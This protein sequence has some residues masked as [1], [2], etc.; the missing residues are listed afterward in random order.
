MKRFALVTLLL[1]SVAGA[2]V[3]LRMDNATVGPV[4]YLNCE[5]DAGLS[6]TRDAGAVGFLDCAVGTP[7]TRGCV[8]PADQSWTGP[9]RIAGGTQDVCVA[10]ASLTACSSP[11]AGLEQCCSTH[12]NAEVW[13]NGTTNV[14]LTGTTASVTLPPIYVNG[15]L[16]A[17]LAFLS[18][19]SLPYPYT[20][21]S[22][23]GYI[24]AGVGTTQTL[25]FSDGAN[26]CDCPIDCSAGATNLTCSGNCSYATSTQVAAIITSDGC[27]TPTTA[28]GMLTPAGYR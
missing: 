17:H 28:K 5:K 2:D 10:H 22:V 19:W 27:T 20:I 24:M 11:N 6:C 21:T 1:A 8:E 4:Q 25:R 13:C 23:S 14:E 26:F 7:S 18:S 3:V 16:G 15:L 9:K 12:G